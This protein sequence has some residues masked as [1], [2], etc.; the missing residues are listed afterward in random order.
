MHAKCVVSVR[1]NKIFPVSESVAF[2]FK[3]EPEDAWVKKGT[4]LSSKCEVSS[5]SDVKWSW[6]LHRNV[7]DMEGELLSGN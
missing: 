2:Y 6:K 7:I 3:T 5:K 1:V 4:Y